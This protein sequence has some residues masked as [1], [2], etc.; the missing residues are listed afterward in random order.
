MSASVGDQTAGWWMLMST[1][2]SLL[3]SPQMRRGTTIVE[4]TDK[5]PLWTDDH[6]NLMQVI[7]W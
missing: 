4:P 2:R 3:H 1:D 5:A 7:K 6:I